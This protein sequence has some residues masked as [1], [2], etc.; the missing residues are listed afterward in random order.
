MTELVI[1]HIAISS[2]TFRLMEKNK[3]K[4]IDTLGRSFETEAAEREYLNKL[5]CATADDLFESYTQINEYCR[6]FSWACDGVTRSGKSY[7][8]HSSVEECDS[9]REFV[10]RLYCDAE[11]LLG[12]KP[13]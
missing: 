7:V 4:P 10:Q 13:A 5:H 9:V 1:S 2:K 3:R 6:G 11:E 8:L 12:E